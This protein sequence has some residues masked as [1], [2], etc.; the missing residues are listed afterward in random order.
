M[1]QKAINQIEEILK[2]GEKRERQKKLREYAQRLKINLLKVRKPSGE[3]SEDGLTVLLYDALQA[4]TRRRSQMTGLI[5]VGVFILG[6][7]F[8][9]FFLYAKFMLSALP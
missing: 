2:I 4:R 8:V 7:M 1:G 9:V 5:A 3:I 6:V